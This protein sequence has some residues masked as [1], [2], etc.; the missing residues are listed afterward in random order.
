[1]EYINKIKNLPIRE[2]RILIIST[3]ILLSFT[4]LLVSNKF[5]I[6]LTIMNTIFQFISSWL[7]SYV[8]TQF[9]NKYYSSSYFTWWVRF[10][11][12]T[13]VGVIVWMTLFASFGKWLKKNALKSKILK[14]IWI[15]PDRSVDCLT[16]D[17][18]Y[19]VI[20]DAFC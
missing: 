6:R 14:L 12:L 2:R 4:V 11:L 17:L 18:W 7:L 1:M 13:I 3:L 10:Y 16:G 5:D 9:Y 19:W 8:F 20:V 15:Y